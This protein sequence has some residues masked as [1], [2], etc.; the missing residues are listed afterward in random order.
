LQSGAN[1][2]LRGLLK[3]VAKTETVGVVL[4]Y[5]SSS[6]NTAH[7]PVVEI[8]IILFEG[9]KCHNEQQKQEP[10]SLFKRGVKPLQSV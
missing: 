8:V 2:N 5:F 6:L 10:I 4:S 1:F 3:P 7:F 9:G